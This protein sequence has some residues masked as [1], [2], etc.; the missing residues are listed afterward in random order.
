MKRKIFYILLVLILVGVTG[1]GKNNEKITMTCTGEK[2]NSSGFEVQNVITYNFSEEQYVTDYSNITNQKFD[3]KSLYETYKTA[4]EE[5]AKDTSIENVTYD[6]KSEDENMTLVFTMT[7]KNINVDDAETEEEKENYKVKNLL[8]TNESNG[9]I[10][11]LEG[12]QK[13]EL[14]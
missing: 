1:C 8:E 11:K 4:Q 13:S 6:L 7:I 5:S 3:D 2:D 9:Y 14:K 10:C 12:I